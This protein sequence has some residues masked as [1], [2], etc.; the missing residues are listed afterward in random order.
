MTR[1]T[2]LPSFCCLLTTVLQN[3]P[4]L[5]ESLNHSN[6]ALIPPPFINNE[7]GVHSQ[8]SINMHLNRVHRGIINIVMEYSI[9]LE[10]SLELLIWLKREDSKKRE[11]ELAAWEADLK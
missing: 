7:G 10:W 5:V 2:G 3:F 6:P 11:K 9:S 8:F 1:L 4:L